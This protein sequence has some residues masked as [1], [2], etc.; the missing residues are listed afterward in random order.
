MIKIYLRLLVL[1]MIGIQFTSCITA[2]RV[3]YL[4]EPNNI[5]PAYSDSLSYEDYRLRIGDKIYVRVYSTH[6][7]TNALFNG[8]SQQSSFMLQ[9][10]SSYAD[11]YS[12]T[13]QPNGNIIFPMIGEVQMLGLT[14]REASR[15]LE[16][17]IAPLYEFSNVELR[18]IGRYFS[19]IGG[20]NTGYYPILREKINIFQ[21]LA[22][23]G[24]VGLFGDRSRIRIIRETDNGTVIRQFDLRS[25]DLIHSEYYFVEP[26]D[27]IYIQTLDEQFFSILNLPGLFATTI[28]TFSFGVFLY[29][30]FFNIP[31]AN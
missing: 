26:N 24:D 7:E 13:V 2:R 22:M 3:N 28:S 31:K 29:N 15:H 8:G 1:L 5:I 20:G 12:Y 21:A 23:A 18:V 6:D 11:L 10:N 25:A 17:A 4:Q 16:S 30:I 27:V 19:V 14:V 9:G